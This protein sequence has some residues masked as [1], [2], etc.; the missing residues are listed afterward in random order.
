MRGHFISGFRGRKLI[1]AKR[2]I[3]DP[4]HWKLVAAAS[5]KRRV[6]FS[7]IQQSDVVGLFIVNARRDVRI[8]GE[9][10]PRIDPHG[11]R[12]NHRPTAY[13]HRNRRS[14]LM[15]PR[16]ITSAAMPGQPS[17]QHVRKAEAAAVAARR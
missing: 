16:R 14:Q 11:R 9:P 7:T 17:P 2:S 4:H 8:A 5:P 10:S 15:M 1:Q 13:E 3:H 6:P 12:A